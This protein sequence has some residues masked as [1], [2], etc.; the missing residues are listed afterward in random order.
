MIYHETLELFKK[1][2]NVLNN[3]SNFDEILKGQHSGQELDISKITFENSWDSSY[4]AALKKY[5]V[6]KSKRTTSSKSSD[7]VSSLIKKIACKLPKQTPDTLPNEL[8]FLQNHLY[9]VSEMSVYYALAK[10]NKFDFGQK[11]LEWAKKLMK[12]IYSKK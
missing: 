8:E 6:N 12:L 4:I 9:K 3:F 10:E 2:C 5:Y 1:T 11:I 7:E